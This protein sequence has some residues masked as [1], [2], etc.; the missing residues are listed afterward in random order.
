MNC[1]H[2]RE[3]LPELLY[4]ALPP[5]EAAQ[6]TY[7]LALCSA[8]R[9]EYAALERVRRL[10]DQVPAP[11]IPIDL[12]HLY[13]QASQHQERR[14]RRW[15]RAAV[16]L[17]G[18]AAALLLV[19]GLRLE[20]RLETNQVVLRWG[21]GPRTSVRIAGEGLKTSPPLVERDNLK[22]PP[23]TWN[24]LQTL[25][26]L[27]YNLADDIQTVEARLNARDQRRQDEL[28][29]LRQRFN[30]LRS[31]VQKQLTE[32]MGYVAALNTARFGSPQKGEKQ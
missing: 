11:E 10:L 17:I 21:N 32:T 22:E 6:L 4:K 27:I 14:L 8:C 5:A 29:A 12:P 19:V 23:V 13:R 31:Q 24:E 30:D 16:G 1:N 9:E 26:L 25:R 28:V 15:R 2:V 7:H 3:Q 18:V 20:V